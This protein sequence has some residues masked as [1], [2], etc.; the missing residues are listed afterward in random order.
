MWHPLWRVPGSSQKKVK[1]RE[2]VN[3]S[4]SVF[5]YPKL[6][7]CFTEEFISGYRLIAPLKITFMKNSVF[8]NTT[9][10]SQLEANRRFWGTYRLHLEGRRISQGRNQHET[11][12]EQSSA[13]YLL[14]TKR[15]WR[16]RRQDTPSINFQLTT[17]RDMPEDSASLWEIQILH[18]LMQVAQYCLCVYRTHRNTNNHVI[19]CRN[20]IRSCSTHA[21]DS[22]NNPRDTRVI[23]SLDA[24]TLL[25]PDMRKFCRC[26]HGVFASKTRA[27]SGILLRT[28]ITCC[29]SWSV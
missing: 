20:Y 25:W 6:I 24:R 29:C 4:Q 8:W 19:W 15:P 7:L 9:S 16:L 5:L 17:F 14:H 28:E 26:D 27:H 3:V 23:V 10:C 11:G 13:C 2:R 21:M 18:R 1:S 12:R 22:P